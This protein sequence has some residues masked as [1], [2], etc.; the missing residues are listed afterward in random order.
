MPTIKSVDLYREETLPGSVEGDSLYFV[1]VAGENFCKLFQTNN[2]GTITATL[3]GL[4]PRG[5]YA[6]GTAYTTGDVATNQG[7]S[8]IAKQDTTGNAPPTLPTESNAYWQLL[9]SPGED[10]PTYY[11]PG[12]AQTVASGD[13][14][15]GQFYIDYAAA[16]AATITNVSAAVLL[17]SGEAGEFVLRI[18]NGDGD[19]KYGPVTVEYGTPLDATVS[20]SRS[21]GEALLVAG[22]GKGAPVGAGEGL[23]HVEGATLRDGA[24]QAG[25]VRRRGVAP[26]EWRGLGFGKAGRRAILHVE[27]VV[28]FHLQRVQQAHHHVEGRALFARCHFA[29]VAFVHADGVGQRGLRH[30]AMSQRLSQFEF[31]TA[32]MRHGAAPPRSSACEQFA[33]CELCA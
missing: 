31:H 18:K 13:V 19:T 16:G 14:A 4:R 21:E 23:L 9:A 29:D 6:G 26:A 33:M 3:V 7:G 12:A 11:D 28:R 1:K 8:W 20:I 15:E 17:S 32:I 25:Q 22:L 2:E 10:G 27:Q 5:A 24:L 30:A